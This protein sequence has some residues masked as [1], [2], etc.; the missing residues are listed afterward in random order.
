MRK[1]LRGKVFFDSMEA[2][3]FRKK[4]KQENF[5][6]IQSIWFHVPYQKNQTFAIVVIY[7]E[8]KEEVKE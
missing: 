2:E 1:T 3:T 6:S 8:K 7:L 4:L 5:L